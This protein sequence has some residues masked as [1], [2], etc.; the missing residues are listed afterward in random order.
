MNRNFLCPNI[1]S[2]NEPIIKM[3]KQFKAKWKKP[4]CKNIAVNS[5]QY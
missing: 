4:A 2:A 3:L 5:R 1:D